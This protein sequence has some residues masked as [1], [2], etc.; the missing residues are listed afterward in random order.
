MMFKHLD[1]TALALS[2]SSFAATIM[3]TTLMFYYV[4]VFL[5]LYGIS[6]EWFQ[7]TQAIFLVWNAVNDPLLGYIVDHVPCSMHKTRRHTILYGAPVFAL[8]F[9]IPWFPWTDVRDSWLT[10]LHLLFSLCF[11]DTMFTYVLL[12]VASLNTEISSDHNGRLQRSRYNMIASFLGSVVIFICEYT[13]DG[14]GSFHTFQVCCIVIA[15]LAWLSL[16]YTGRRCHTQFELQQLKNSDCI[17]NSGYTDRSTNLPIWRLTWQLIT[18]R[19]FISFVTTNL[20]SEFHRSYLI[21]FANIFCETLIPE[22]ALPPFIRSC[23]FGWFVVSPQVCIIS[24]V[25]EFHNTYLCH[26]LI[27]GE[28]LLMFS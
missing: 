24:S 26:W 17:M 9:L 11:Y 8:S 15:V 2:A 12:T 18:Q 3:H 20:L 23:F 6:E 7:F 28:G 16:T 10:G 25:K 5:N 22:T 1:Q 27:Q 4:K 14:L 19:N 13:S 21:N